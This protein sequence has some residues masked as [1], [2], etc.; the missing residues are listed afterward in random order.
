MNKANLKLFLHGS[1]VSMIGVGTLGIMNYFIRRTLALNL[2]ETDFGFIYSAFA[3]LMLI[4]VF[5]DLGMAQSTTILMSKSFA[6]NDLQKSKK[7]FTLTFIVKMLLALIAF[8]SLEALA[9]YLQ[10][11]YFAYP[12]S[13]ILLMLIFL[14][15]P[16]QALESS[17]LCVFTARKAFMTQTVLYNIKAFIILAGVLFFIKSYGIQSSVICFIAASVIISVLAFRIIKNYGISFISFKMIKAD[18]LKSV[19]SLSYWITISTAGISIMY[20]MDTVCLTWL[21]DLKSVAMYNIALPI[22]QIAQSFFVFPAIFT[23][24]VAEMWQKKDYVGI[25]R[26]CY[27]ANLLM[28]STLPIFILTGIYFASDIIA[29]LFDEKYIA[30]APAVTILWGGMVFFSIASFNINALNSGNK[31]K[32]AAY[33]VASCVI[34]NFVLNIIL[35][36]KFDYIGAALATAIT[37]LLM[38][39]ASIIILMIVF[40]KNR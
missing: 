26:S 4:L 40:N 2:S 27:L 22:M 3:L 32:N 28:L 15:I 10:R 14:L 20:Y 21:M 9:P 39:L 34:I 24:F 33:M 11:S 6:V 38:A 5:I 30:V 12:G 7:I 36:P 1:A 31:Q 35:I 25:K 19:F 18:D 16:A 37:Y 29:L 13:P 23:P 8:I 17:F